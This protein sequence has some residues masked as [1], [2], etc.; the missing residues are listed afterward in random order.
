MNYSRNPGVKWRI[1][2]GG[3]LCVYIRYR[4]LGVKHFC[5]GPDTAVMY[6]AF[7]HPS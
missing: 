3:L 2:Q 1:S 4:D 5:M 6:L 7:R